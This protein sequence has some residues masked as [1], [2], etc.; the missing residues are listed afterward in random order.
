MRQETLR[1]VLKVALVVG[2]VSAL[3]PM[4]HAQAIGIGELENMLVP[5][6]QKIERGEELYEQNCA[7]CHGDNG[8]GMTGIKMA[9]TDQTF[10]T[11]NF[12]QAEYE[13]GG[14]PVQIYNA[15]T[16]GLEEALPPEQ[17]P[18]A[19][20]QADGATQ[21]PT[22]NVPTHPVYPQLQYQSRWDL[23]HYVRSLGPTDDIED[24]DPLL[25]KARERA[26]KGVCDP[27]I[28][29]SV[30]EKMEMKGEEQLELGKEVYD[31]NCAS[32]H[33]DEGA[34]D[35]P[36]ADA[37]NPP[38][39]SF[40]ET[41]VEWT[42]G[43]SQLA[44]YNTLQQGIEGTSMASYSNL[45]DEE[46]W[47]L[48]H[49]VRQWIPDEAKK[50]V[51]QEQVT[52]ACRAMSRPEPPEPISINTAMRAL[53]KD[54]AEER[55]IRLQRYGVVE[56]ARD[57]DP[58]R[59]EQVYVENCISCHGVDGVGSPKKGPYGAQPPYLYLDVGRLAAASAGGTAED[60]AERSISGVHKT[61]PD[62]NAVSL[63]TRQEWEDLQAYVAGFGGVGEITYEEGST[64]EAAAG[65]EESLEVDEAAAE[66]QAPE[67]A[68]GSQ[69]AQGDRDGSG[70]QPAEAGSTGNTADSAPANDAAPGDT[71]DGP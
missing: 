34:G 12:Q 10:E 37:L 21:G 11:T 18:T 35:G 66:D 43:T 52:N 68:T 71:P 23:V 64:E 25:A 33:G 59:G 22:A 41:G 31:Q 49:Y 54:Q 24:P 56:L 15:I 60:F 53:V 16:F 27:S 4:V 65:V 29:E 5:T 3:A 55:A 20:T 44:I 28:R 2:G 30:T 67:G 58:A 9:G 36:A 17:R 32:C 13:Y 6:K 47:A 7:T 42:N 38:P 45:P 46:I 48:V 69:G 50:D 62:M 51:T 39:R 19:P 1:K 57:A 8:K 61:L 14:G 70:T 26:A 40:V 63:L